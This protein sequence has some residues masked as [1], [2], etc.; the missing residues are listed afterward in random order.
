MTSGK[1]DDGG[2]YFPWHMG[3]S[4]RRHDVYYIVVTVNTKEVH[5]KEMETLFNLLIYF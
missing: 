5:I 1:Y 4:F 3:K 2:H